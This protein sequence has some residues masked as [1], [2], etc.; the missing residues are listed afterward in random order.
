MR[1]KRTKTKSPPRT[2]SR[3]T[4]PK[5]PPSKPQKPV[6]QHVKPRVLRK[7]AKPKRQLLP[8]PPRNSPSPLGRGVGV[9]AKRT[10]TKSPPRTNSRP[11]TPK[12]PP[13][14]PQKPAPP[15]AKRHVLRKTAKPKRQP[16]LLLPR[17]NPLPPWGRVGVGAANKAAQLLTPIQ[18]P[19]RT[20]SRPTTLKSP[21]SKRQKPA[22]PRAK[23]RVLPKTA[24][25]Q[26]DNP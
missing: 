15:R 19:P 2:N 11:T 21:L 12:P 17:F 1:A 7:T 13:S 24:K 3:P 6:R 18:R 14:K 8:L 20:N 25:R 23:P 16:P 5:P 4:T 26:P 22:P 9:R 10:K